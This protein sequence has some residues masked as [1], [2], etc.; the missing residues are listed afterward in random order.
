M[1]S[2]AIKYL[3]VST[4]PRRGVLVVCKTLLEAV[5][6]K[7][8]FQKL[9]KSD[10]EEQLIIRRANGTE[11]DGAEEGFVSLIELLKGMEQRAAQRKN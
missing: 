3:L 11:L 10:E 1:N 7:L 2:P 8:D 4:S 6:C 9:K 5:T